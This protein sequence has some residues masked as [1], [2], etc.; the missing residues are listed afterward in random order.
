MMILVNI[1][2]VICFLYSLFFLV[3]TITVSHK[4]AAILIKVVAFIGVVTP[5]LFWL[6]HYLN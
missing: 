4:I 5:L 1:A 6:K 3:A 2:M